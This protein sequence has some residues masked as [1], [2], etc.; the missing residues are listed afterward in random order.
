DHMPKHTDIVS[1]RLTEQMIRQGGLSLSQALRYGLE[2]TDFS[3]LR[4]GQELSATAE[5]AT[6][7]MDA[8]IN[9]EP[10]KIEAYLVNSSQ[11]ERKQIGIE[12]QS[13]FGVKLDEVLG[14]KTPG[15][16]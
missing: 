4:P 13:Q 2:A 6:S 8:L 11:T 15:S 1:D 14:R 9:K 5:R 12:F 10:L 3:N 16:D 7:I